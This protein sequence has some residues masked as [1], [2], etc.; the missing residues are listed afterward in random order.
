MEKDGEKRNVITR[1]CF[2]KIPTIFEGLRP[3]LKGLRSIRVDPVTQTSS[4]D[5]VQWNGQ[6]E[7][8]K[9]SMLIFERSDG[10]WR[11]KNITNCFE[12]LKK[13]KKSNEILGY[14]SMSR[15]IEKLPYITQ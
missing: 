9:I 11:M 1:C 2:T 5:G 4:N 3:S 15:Q 8:S 7:I 13:K 12:S 14:L 6:L 10:I